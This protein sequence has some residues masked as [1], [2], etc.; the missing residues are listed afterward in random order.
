MNGTLSFN[1]CE[2]EKCIDVTIIDDGRVERDESFK[3]FLEWNG[4]DYMDSILYSNSANGTI[5]IQDNDGE[6]SYTST[7]RIVIDFHFC[8]G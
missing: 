3:I 6:Y 4:A 5:T 7:Y 8:S 2:P 1:P